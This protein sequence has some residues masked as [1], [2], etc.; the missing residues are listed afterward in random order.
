MNSVKLTILLNTF[1]ILQMVLIVIF[2]AAQSSKEKEYRYQRLK[3]VPYWTIGIA[4]KNEFIKKTAHQQWTVRP[5]LVTISPPLT[6]YTLHCEKAYIE[7]YFMITPRTQWLQYLNWHES[8]DGQQAV[9]VGDHWPDILKAGKDIIHY[10]TRNDNI[11]KELALNTLERFLLISYSCSTNNRTHYDDSEI[12]ESI[13]QM[14]QHLDTPL[15]I[16][17]MAQMCHMSE[18]SYAHRFKAHTGDS[19]AHY[20]ERLRLQY[21][22]RLLL[23]SHGSIQ[24]IAFEVGFSNPYHFST[25]FSKQ[26]RQSPR[27]YRQAPRMES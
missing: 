19:P 4:V 9:D 10:R 23:T 3:N 26:F 6:S 15:S 27:A 11:S 13:N 2:S 1:L 18:S 22:Q 21:A 17:E 8:V 25:R 12:I 20:H 24:E 7:I 16:S 14:N 5:G